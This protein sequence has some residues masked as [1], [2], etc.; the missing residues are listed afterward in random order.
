VSRRSASRA[1][2]DAYVG[3]FALEFDPDPLRPGVLQ[4]DVEARGRSGG[5]KLHVLG[6][7]AEDDSSTRRRDRA[8]TPGG[9][10][11]RCRAG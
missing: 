5:L 6:P 7:V 1:R 8:H 11:R 9:E 10:R 3:L 4:L 2:L